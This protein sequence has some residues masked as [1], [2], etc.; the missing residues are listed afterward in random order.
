MDHITIPIPEGLPADQ[1]H[2]LASYLTDH[3]KQMTGAGPAL[4]DDPEVRAEIIQRIKR[5]MAD[6]EAGRFCDGTE[7][8]RRMAEFLSSKQAG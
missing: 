7:A 1:K 8:R 6:M 3:V 5:G 4:D 2:D